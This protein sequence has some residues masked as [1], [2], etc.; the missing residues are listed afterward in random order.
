M[1]N[2]LFDDNQAVI[3]L[4]PFSNEEE[5]KDYITAMYLTDYIFGGMD[6]SAYWVLPISVS[7]FGIYCKEKKVDEYKA[8]FEDNSK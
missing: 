2:L 1:K 7:N 6:K 8:F 5:A 3:Y 4:S